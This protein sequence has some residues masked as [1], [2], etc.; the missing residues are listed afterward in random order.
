MKLLAST[1]R[2]TGAYVAP[3][4]PD[5]STLTYHTTF[6]AAEVSAR[7][8]QAKAQGIWE[9]QQ[10]LAELRLRQTARDVTPDFFAPVKR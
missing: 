5:Y 9:G 3:H 1:L 8:A 4:V 2:Q 10:L 6:D 7:F